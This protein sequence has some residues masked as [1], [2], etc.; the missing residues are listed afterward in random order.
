MEWEYY[1]HS[2]GTAQVFATGSFSAPEVANMLNWYGAQG[3]ELVSTFQTAAN[4]GGTVAVAFIFKR[5][6]AGGV[7][8]VTAHSA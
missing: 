1:V 7:P 8:G 2:L 4:N 5:R 6:K 3:W